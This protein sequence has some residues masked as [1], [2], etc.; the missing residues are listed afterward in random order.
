ML[1]TTLTRSI[2]AALAASLLAAPAP[3]GAADG[4][5]A[6]ALIGPVV[7]N[8][9]VTSVPD[10]GTEEPVRICWTMFRPAEATRRHKVPM[11]MHS[12][13]WGG[14]RTRDWRAFSRWTEHGY[15]VL[16]YDQRGFGESGGQ[17]YVENP[18]VEGHDVARLVR[19]IS[20][21]R[22]VR[23]DGPGDPRLGAIG[24]SY[25]GG[26]QFLGAFTSLQRRG[27]EVFDASPPRSRGAR[28]TPASRPRA[29]SERSGPPP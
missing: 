7:T 5:T 20:R 23:K 15:A 21:K 4:E 3:A 13:G 1:R 17:A 18:A 10:P 6:P 26:F 25:G 22:W 27:T 28:S 14:S 24:G 19:M 12:H 8:G 2:V 29:S 9:C 16:S 11:V